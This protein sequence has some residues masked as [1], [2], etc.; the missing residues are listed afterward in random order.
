MSHQA[1]PRLP[2][3]CFLLLISV[4]D[5]CSC[6]L[7]RSCLLDFLFLLFHPHQ[8]SEPI[9]ITIVSYL[10]IY[11]HNAHVTFIFAYCSIVEHV[12]IL[13]F[14]CVSVC[15]QESQRSV[16]SVSTVPETRG[17]TLRQEVEMHCGGRTVAEQQHTLCPGMAAVLPQCCFSTSLSARITTSVL[18]KTRVD[19]TE[20]G[21]LLSI[22][23]VQYLGLREL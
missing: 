7:V 12:F 1:W 4:G 16:S 11:I 6:V 10:H 21:E 5:F 20:S 8:G 19:P 3:S 15:A 13:I 2:L 14:L 22:K 17:R 18:W 9:S 23:Y